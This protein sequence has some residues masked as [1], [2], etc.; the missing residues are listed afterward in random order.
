MER[1]EM[2]ALR[3]SHIAISCKDP[4]ATERFYTRYFGFKRARVIPAGEEQIVFIKSGNMYL[5]LFQAREKAP[6]PP[7]SQ[8]GPWYPGWRHIAFQVD[9]VDARLAEM[10]DDAKITLG[11]LDFDAFIPGWRTVWVA[12]PDGNIVEISQGY[13]DQENPPPLS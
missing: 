10:G 3:F 8:D 7:A 1:E 5:E 2:T 12:D 13:V 11:P 4:I 9:D 6:I